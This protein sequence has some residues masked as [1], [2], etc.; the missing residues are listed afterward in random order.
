MVKPSLLSM[1][2]VWITEAWRKFSEVNWILRG[3]VASCFYRRA[4]ILCMALEGKTNDSPSHSKLSSPFIQVIWQPLGTT[5]SIGSLEVPHLC[6]HVFGNSCLVWKI[7]RVQSDF[8]KHI[9]MPKNI[10][11][12]KRGGVYSFVESWMT[13]VGH[14]EI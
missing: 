14:Q 5:N 13:C 10:Y 1:V 8:N 7:H 3:L 9:H 4:W 12:T 2:Y 6:W 11:K